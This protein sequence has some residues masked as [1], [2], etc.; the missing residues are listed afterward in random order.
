MTLGHCRLK[1]SSND[2]AVRFRADHGVAKKDLPRTVPMEQSFLAHYIIVPFH[3]YFHST[4]HL[5]INKRITYYSG[6]MATK[7]IEWLSFL[8]HYGSCFFQPLRS[9]RCE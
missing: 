5:K 3:N 8:F 9:D 1:K 2:S 6:F 7:V 4:L